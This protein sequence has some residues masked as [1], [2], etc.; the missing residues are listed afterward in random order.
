MKHR[1]LNHERYTVAA[2]DDTIARGQRAD[3]VHLRDAAAR[4]PEIL[5]KILRVC[6]A[7]SADPSAQR[8]HLWRYYA[9][10]RVA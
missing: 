5:R 6:A 9:E 1:H 3:W 10:R 2:I 4:D 7:H 8:Y